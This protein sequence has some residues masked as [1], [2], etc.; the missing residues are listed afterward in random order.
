MPLLLFALLVAQGAVNV[1]SS[2]NWTAPDGEFESE[3]VSPKQTSIYVMC[4][5]DHDI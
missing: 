2:V 3:L 4:P 1:G 5:S